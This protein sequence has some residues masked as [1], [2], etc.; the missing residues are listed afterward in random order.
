MSGCDWEDV[1]PEECK[2]WGTLGVGTAT[3]IL[4][5]SYINGFDSGVK[6]RLSKFAED[7]KLGGEVDCREG[8]IRFKKV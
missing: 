4:F 2:Q 7:T 6:S 5:I 1:S 3:I 8:F